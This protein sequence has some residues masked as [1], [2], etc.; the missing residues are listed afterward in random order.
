MRITRNDLLSRGGAA[1]IALVLLAAARAAQSEPRSSDQA[2]WQGIAARAAT[3]QQESRS[4]REESGP[5]VREALLREVRLYVSLYPGGSAR[6]DAITLELRLLAE[7]GSLRGDFGPLCQRV[8]ELLASPPSDVVAAEADWRRLA[9]AQLRRDASTTQPAMFGAA[10]REQRWQFLRSHPGSRHALR[11]AEELAEQ[12]VRRRDAEESDAV[13]RWL[14]EHAPDAPAA[15]RV[16]LRCALER[17]IGFEFLAVVDPAAATQPVVPTVVVISAG[18]ERR[19][20]QSVTRPAN[21]WLLV[22]AEQVGVATGEIGGAA[23]VLATPPGLE[24]L[25][26]LA[27]ELSQPLLLTV[28]PDGRVSGYA[29]PHSGLIGP[30]HGSD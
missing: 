10:W 20:L 17:T 23:R 1:T 27:T 21:V 16:R 4:T 14:A 22:P 6:D 5:L 25:T 30:L 28:G 19:G 13:Q 9:C 7:L 2:L 3:L 12:A 15:R 24:G 26:S 11:I 29:A 8:D 18:G